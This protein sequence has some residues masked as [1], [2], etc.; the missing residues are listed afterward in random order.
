[1]TYKRKKRWIKWTSK[2]K[3]SCSSKDTVKREKKV[4]YRQ[5]ERY[6]QSAY[7][8]KNILILLHFRKW[9]ETHQ[10]FLSKMGQ[11]KW[12]FQYPSLH[13]WLTSCKN[14]TVHRTEYFTQGSRYGFTRGRPVGLLGLVVWFMHT[15]SFP[16]PSS[17]CLHQTLKMRKQSDE[18]KVW[19]LLSENWPRLFKK[20]KLQIKG[21][22]TALYLKRPVQFVNFD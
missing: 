16:K 15:S 17:Q 7:L 8:I 18:S 2:I 19:D 10:G 4:N 1:M 21:G 5:R 12:W 9:G 13:R 6:L 11:V 20:W 22:K 3:N 14:R